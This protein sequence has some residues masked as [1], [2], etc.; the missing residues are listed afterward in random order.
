MNHING[1]K[2]GMFFGGL[3]GFVHILWSFFVAVG[4]AESIMDFAYSLHFI[5]STQTVTSFDFMTA[6]GLVVFA[7]LLG[8]ALGCVA[9]LIWNYVRM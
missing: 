5:R 6:V 9:A 2:L 8:Y 1:H 7:A 3:A 4:W